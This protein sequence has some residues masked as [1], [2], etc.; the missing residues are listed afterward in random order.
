MQFNLFAGS[1]AKFSTTVALAGILTLA[2]STITA[3]KTFA[4]EG[5]SN[6]RTQ[7]MPTEP[8]NVAIDSYTDHFFYAANPALNQRKLRASDKAYIRE[9]NTI[10]RAIAPL[11]KSSREVCMRTGDGSLY[12][13]F[14][15]GAD[16]SS[17]DSL[18]DVIFYH[19]NP[20]L[21]GQKLQPKTAAAREWSSIRNQMYVSTCGI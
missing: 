16:R 15:L 6:N 1:I 9:W 10:R 8:K 13:E 3:N 5:E 17:Y 2:G 20:R 11:I 12:W 21:A 14:D 18:A 4:G 19:R 7:T